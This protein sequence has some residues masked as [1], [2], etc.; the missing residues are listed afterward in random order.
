MQKTNKR[1]TSCQRVSADIKK[2]NDPIIKKLHHTDRTAYAVLLRKSN[3]YNF[4][5]KVA[6]ELL[7][8]YRT[9]LLSQSRLQS[10]GGFTNPPDGSDVQSAG[11]LANIAGG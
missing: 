3:D 4:D 7:R 1:V 6:T 10:T 5:N 2:L 11:G 8:C 9:V